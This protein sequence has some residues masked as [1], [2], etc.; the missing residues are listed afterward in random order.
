M[1][2][3]SDS[4][5]TDYYNYLIS[6][7]ICT[8]FSAVL[9]SDFIPDAS[10]CATSSTACPSILF[11]EIYSVTYLSIF[12]CATSYYACFCNSISVDF[13]ILHLLFNSFRIFF[14]FTLHFTTLVVGS[15]PLLFL[16]RFQSWISPFYL[17]FLFDTYYYS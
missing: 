12:I 9:F 4:A 15:F 1:I 14:S 3:L 5:F 17:F 8:N 7:F 16:F 6:I 13:F 2:L 11:H 10:I